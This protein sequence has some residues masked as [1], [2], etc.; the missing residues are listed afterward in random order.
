MKASSFLPTTTARC[1]SQ[2]HLPSRGR[3]VLFLAGLGPALPTALLPAAAVAQSVALDEGVFRISLNGAVVGREEFSVRRV[4]SGEQ[5]RIVLRGNGETQLPTGPQTVASVLAVQ[6][7]SFEVEEYQLRVVGGTAAVEVYLARSGN[8]YLTRI[9]SPSGEEVREYRAGPGSVLLD[10]GV[11]HHYH[12]LGPYLDRGASVSLNV[13]APRGG[14]QVRMTLSP[15]GEEEIGV[16]GETVRA[17]RFRL[18][19]TQSA[20]EVWFDAQ[21]RLLRVSLPAEGWLAQRESLS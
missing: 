12:L 11:A 16:G 17:R 19:G 18:E 1:S 3:W 9:L 10:Q 13:L 21:G 4:G 8:R 20:A 5:G 15:A 2:G 7:P 14:R 6:G